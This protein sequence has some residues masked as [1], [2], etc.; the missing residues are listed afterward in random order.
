MKSDHKNPDPISKPTGS[1]HILGSHDY[2]PEIL[3][4]NTV[5]AVQ[6]HNSHVAVTDQSPNLEA[7]SLRKWKRLTD[8][9]PLCTATKRERET[10]E[11]VQPELPTKKLQVSREDDSD[12]LMAEAVK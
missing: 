9:N 3:G 1:P 7:S 11:A 4:D 12:F 5:T 6:D 10:D 2:E 8:Q